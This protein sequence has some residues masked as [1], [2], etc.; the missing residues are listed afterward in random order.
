[1]KH[2]HQFDPEYK[3]VMQKNVKTKATAP[4]MM[5]NGEVAVWLNIRAGLVKVGNIKERAVQSVFSVHSIPISL[6]VSPRGLIIIGCEDGR[7]MLLQVP[8]SSSK[9]G[10]LTVLLNEVTNRL[11]MLSKDIYSGLTNNNK[12][13]NKKSSVCSII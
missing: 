5:P 10:R 6:G 1:M 13:Q 2:V 8:D 3:D 12:T 7:L 9:E 11:T 4:K